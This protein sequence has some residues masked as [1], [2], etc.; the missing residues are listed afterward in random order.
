M[1]H[2]PHAR[3]GLPFK[4]TMQHKYARPHGA[5]LICQAIPRFEFVLQTCAANL[6]QQYA[7]I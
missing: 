4:V 2:V 5:M 3:G 7:N 6:N 1:A